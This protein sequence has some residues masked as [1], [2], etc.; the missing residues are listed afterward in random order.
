MEYQK[1][2]IERDSD[3]HVSAIIE[4]LEDGSMV[5]KVVGRDENNQVTT[6]TPEPF[7]KTI[8]KKGL[9]AIKKVVEALRTYNKNTRK[10][11]GGK[12]M[13]IVTDKLMS[14]HGVVNRDMCISYL[15]SAKDTRFSEEDIIKDFRMCEKTGTQRK[16]FIVKDGIVILASKKAKSNSGKIKDSG[17]SFAGLDEVLETNTPKDKFLKDISE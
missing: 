13:N 8:S 10:L 14:K 16:D 15:D 17:D 2:V 1:K 11:Y 12:R 3:G 4:T 7:I 5:K 9:F 6:I